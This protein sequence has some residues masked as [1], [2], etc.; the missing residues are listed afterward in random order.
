M[1]V[2]MCVSVKRVCACV[3]MGVCVKQVCVWEGVCEWIRRREGETVRLTGEYVLEE[4]WMTDICISFW[5]WNH[6]IIQFTFKQNG[7]IVYLFLWIDLLSF[8]LKTLCLSKSQTHTHLLTRTYCST[9]VLSN[10]HM[11]YQ[12]H[13]PSIHKYTHTSSHAHTLLLLNSKRCFTFFVR[14]RYDWMKGFSNY[15][16]SYLIIWHFFVFFGFLPDPWR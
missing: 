14:A 2:C 16:S 1:D 7:V 15:P 6:W 10:S 8:S 11:K 4:E 3:W 9:L 13:P 5:M 12:T